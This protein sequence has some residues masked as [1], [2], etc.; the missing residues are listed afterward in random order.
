MKIDKKHL[1]NNDTAFDWANSGPKFN[2]HFTM[3]PLI[4]SCSRLPE[5]EL[6]YSN[7]TLSWILIDAFF[8]GSLSIPC[9]I[10]IM[11]YKTRSMVIQG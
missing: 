5:N 7:M 4:I 6:H 3:Q 8:L 11:S 1:Y 10:H 2:H 9:G